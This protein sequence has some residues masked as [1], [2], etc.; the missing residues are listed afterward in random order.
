MLV[1][2][3]RNVNVAY[4]AGMEV[5]LSDW[6]AEGSRNGEVLVCPTP[7]MTVYE[8]PTERVL[9]DGQRDANPFFHLFESLWMLAGRDDPEYL[10]QFVADFGARYAEPETG[11]LWGAYGH[12]WRHNFMNDQLDVVVGRLRQDPTDRR[13]VIQM[14]DADRDLYD[15]HHD[16]Q[17]RD[18]PCNTQVYPRVRRAVNGESYLDITVTCRSNDLIWGA[19]GANAVH[20]SVLQEYLAACIGVKVGTYYHL[21]NNMHVYTS[22]LQR[23]QN[24][25]ED[26]ELLDVYSVE[27]SPAIV[28]PMFEGYN[29]DIAGQVTLFV[30]S[31]EDKRIDMPW[32]KT[33]AQP[34]LRA[35][36]QYKLGDRE[37]A[38]RTVVETM[39]VCDWRLAAIRWLNRRKPTSAS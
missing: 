18:V 8:R 36:Q 30:D 31:P 27:S 39:P 15:H 22:V 2:K 17:P 13:C 21:S 20:F 6:H 16:S 29:G 12:R 4:A 25:P 33:I 37:A 26:Q 34:M 9:F 3:A 38:I 32:L 24:K 5:A 7:V 28:I 1:I 19:Y 23:L 10:N 11:E 14:W 35:H